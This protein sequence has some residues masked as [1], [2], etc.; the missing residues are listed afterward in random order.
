MNFQE[1]LEEELIEV[2]EIAIL[3]RQYHKYVPEIKMEL[4]KRLGAHECSVHHF[5]SYGVI[6]RMTKTADFIKDAE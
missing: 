3:E 5:A 1:Y 4:K 2:L 6:P